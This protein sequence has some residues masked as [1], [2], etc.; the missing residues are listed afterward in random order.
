[1]PVRITQYHKDNSIDFCSFLSSKFYSPLML[2]FKK[3]YAMISDFLK[4][5][6]IF[7]LFHETKYIP[8]F[9][10][11]ILLDYCLRA[12]WDF[13]CWSF[14]EQFQ[15]Q[16]KR[17]KENLPLTRVTTTEWIHAMEALNTPASNSHHLPLSPGAAARGHRAAKGLSKLSILWALKF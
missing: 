17:S 1:M 10:V 11:T 9:L 13:R 6:F 3:K 4:F 14:H 7:I 2:F 5:V 8:A 12:F 15:R 16:R